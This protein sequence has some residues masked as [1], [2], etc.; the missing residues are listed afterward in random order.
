MIGYH[1][2]AMLDILGFRQ[3]VKTR[4]LSWLVDQLDFLFAAAE[5]K[6]ASCGLLSAD[7]RVRE[8]DLTLGHLHFS[9]TLMLWTPPMDTEDG[10]FNVL[11][12]SHICNTVANL[13]ALALINGVPLRGGL[14]LGECYINPAK[15]LAVGQPIVDAYLL[16]QEQEWLGAA[17]STEQLCEP[18]AYEHLDEGCGLVR[19]DV[20]T[21]TT[22][23]HELFALDWTR[24]ARMPKIVTQKLWKINARSAVERALS[25]G[26]AAA[27][28]ESVYRKW[29]NAAEF[30]QSQAQRRPLEFIRYRG[31]NEKLETVTDEPV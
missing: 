4:R 30:F 19:Y 14:A 23:S 11:A 29:Q 9:D 27:T 7:D 5:P 13:I 3:L 12:F 24:I 8:R 20:P 18:S 26:L 25:E 28:Q 6:E 22:P 15:Q 16:E 21:K 2:I 17:V 10:D 1:C 31:P